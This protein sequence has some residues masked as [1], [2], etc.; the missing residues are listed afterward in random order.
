ME[1][2]EY[3]EQAEQFLTQYGLVIRT[4]FK[5]DKCPAWEEGTLHIH[6]DR[7]RVTIQR[8]LVTGSIPFNSISFDFWN[9]KNDKDKGIRPTGYDILSTVSSDAFSPT[10]PDEIVAEYGDMKPSQATAAARFAKRLQA[11]FTEEEL[12]ALSEIQ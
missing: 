11:F 9:S 7:Y 8:E 2:N 12:E 10:D 4:A 6:G 3:E 5:G 1:R